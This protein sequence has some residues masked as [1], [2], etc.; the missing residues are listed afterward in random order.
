MKSRKVVSL[1]LLGS[2]FLPS[3]ANAGVNCAQVNKYL[4]TGRTAEDVSD[5]MVVDLAEVKKCQAEGGAAAAG[6]GTKAAPTPEPA[7][8]K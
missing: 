4:A 2:F 8:K 7:P 1:A 6:D 5:T 3:L